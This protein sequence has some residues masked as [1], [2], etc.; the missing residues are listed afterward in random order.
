MPQKPHW[1]LGLDLGPQVFQFQDR[2]HEDL[3]A[4]RLATLFD[5]A[6][7]ISELEWDTQ[8]LATG[9]VALKHVRAILP[10][11]TPVACSQSSPSSCPAR[12]VRDL[13]PRTSVE[14]YL[15]LPKSG[16]GTVGDDTKPR[17]HTRERV[18]VP[19]Y[20]NGGDAVELEWL[21]PNLELRFEG[22]ALERHTTLACGR[23][24]RT[25]AGGI[26]FDVSFVPPVLSI[27][28]S[29]F[30]ASELRRVVDGLASRRTA[31]RRAPLR[32]ASDAPRQWLLGLISGFIPKLSDVIDRRA[33]PHL[34][35]RALVDVVGSLS[36][37]TARGDIAIPAFDYERLG[38]VFGELFLSTQAVLDALAAE[39]YRRVPLRPSDGATLY[40]ELREPGIFRND[41]F[42][43]V[44]GDDV[45]RLR[46][47]VPRMFKIAAWSELP[48]VVMSHSKGL[49]LEPQQSAPAAL[50]NAPGVVYFRLAKGESFTSIFKTSEMGIHHGGLP[51]VRE[52]ILYA[53][54]PATP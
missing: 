42:L 25:A 5:Y 18:L 22:E 9:Q 53:V 39:L 40:A 4:E 20:A 16:S 48:G 11:G 23:L 26:A 32:D 14:I 30:L 7:G 33:H 12:V 28:A 36:A 29:S 44:L 46:A 27:G 49:T 21:R 34:A 19:D 43:A 45:E 2:Y 37:F 24:V 17:R 50:P 15:A 3:I 54:D 13:G 31:L 10:D 35:Y 38:A 51:G 47:E 41:F 6:W 8:G 1:P 52:M